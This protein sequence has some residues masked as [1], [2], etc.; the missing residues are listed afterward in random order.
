ML[1]VENVPSTE[2]VQPVSL[3]MPVASDYILGSDNLTIWL[4]H[5]KKKNK[6]LPTKQFLLN[7]QKLS[8][9]ENNVS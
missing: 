5:M 8:V 2:N 9:Q 6:N 7:Y 4:V 1:E 3:H